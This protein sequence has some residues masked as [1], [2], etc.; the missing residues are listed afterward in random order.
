MTRQTLNFYK[1]EAQLDLDLHSRDCKGLVS[2]GS[3][4][5]GSLLKGSSF[6]FL[7]FKASFC[8]YFLIGL[9]KKRP[10]GLWKTPLLSCVFL[11]PL[12][13]YGP[14]CELLPVVF[15]SSRTS[16]IL[17]KKRFWKLPA[18][19]CRARTVFLI[20]TSSLAALKKITR[21]LKKMEVV[22]WKTQVVYDFESLFSMIHFWFL[23][24]FSYNPRGQGWGGAGQPK[25]THYQQAPS[26]N[27]FIDANVHF[28]IL[29]ICL[30]ICC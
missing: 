7:F 5:K 6:F 21:K 11:L 10:L 22:Y 27:M 15:R 20:Q 8:F 9:D 28:K 3:W 4:L 23:P 13:M 18:R 24:F 19:G 2:R 14:L 25:N 12:V 17:L 1:F 30:A 29:H 26:W 16:R